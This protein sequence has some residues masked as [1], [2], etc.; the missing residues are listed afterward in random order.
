MIKTIKHN[1]AL[2]LDSIGF[3]ASTIC[4]VH[5]VSMPFLLVFLSFYGFNFIANPIVEY[6]FIV[7]SIVIGFFTF[8]HGYFNHHRKIYPFA[9]FILGLMV[10]V[11]SHYFFHGHDETLISDQFLFQKLPYSILAPAGA[12]LIGISHFWNRK[13]SKEFAKEKCAC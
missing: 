5:C 7:L 4:A 8:R 10:I 6:S 9:L 1:L 12:I 11:S 2:K 3:A 13:L